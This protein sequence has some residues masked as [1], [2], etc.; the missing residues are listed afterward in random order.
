MIRK[1]RFFSSIRI[2]F[3]LT[4][5][6]VIA[7]VLILMNTYI[8]MSSR[9]IIFRSKELFLQSQA[10]TIVAQLEE[11]LMQ[12]TPDEDIER[13]MEFVDISGI[14]YVVITDSEGL[15]IYISVESNVTLNLTI[16]EI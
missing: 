14:T 4:Y 3:A 10:S 7:I 8:L 1:L 11:S 16:D 6:S 12:H 2:K 13:I 5:F 9:D 15:P